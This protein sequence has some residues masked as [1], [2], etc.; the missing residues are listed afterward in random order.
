MRSMKRAF[1]RMM[2]LVLFLCAAVTIPSWAKA[3]SLSVRVENGSQEVIGG[4]RLYFDFETNYP[5]N[6]ADKSVILEYQI[7]D[8]KD[9]LLSEKSERSIAKRISF[10]DYMIVPESISSGTKTLNIVVTNEAGLQEETS[11]SFRVVKGRDQTQAYLT[12]LLAGIIPM[13]LILTVRVIQMRT[14]VA[15]EKKIKTAKM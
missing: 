7:F 5:E 11:A 10:T 3:L 9:L 4:D 15:R 1:S 13:L 6:I 8:G 14:Q 2:V 12:L